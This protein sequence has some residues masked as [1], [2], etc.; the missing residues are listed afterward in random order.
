MN[1]KNKTA[2][3]SGANRGIGKALVHELL[4]RGVK[5][6]YAGARQL[7]SLPDFA[8]VRVVPLQ[9]DITKKQQVGSAA[10]IAADADLLI[11]NAGVAAFTSLLG[12]EPDLF[13]RDMQTN[14]YGT[15]EMMRA[16]IPVLEGKEGAA[17]VNVVTVAAFVNF[18]VLGGYSASKAAL[19]SASQGVRIELAPRKIA[20]HT[21]N[22]GPIDT[23]MTQAMDMPKASAEETA[24]RIAEGLEAGDVDIFPDDSGSQMFGVWKGDYRKLEQ[25]VHNMHHGIE[26]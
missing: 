24:R 23:D 15:L 8:D 12:D 5:K 18:P 25:M 21:V 7:G 16:F 10:K 20:V 2:V 14:Y 19:F 6:V 1:L 13:E 11:N 9:L 3:I 17:I 4:K 22:P 26:S